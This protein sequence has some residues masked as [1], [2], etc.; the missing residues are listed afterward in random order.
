MT[1]GNTSGTPQ[2][3]TGKSTAATLWAVVVGWAL[4]R[5]VTAAYRPAEAERLPHPAGSDVGE[6]QHA[7][8]EA[9]HERGRGRR[10]ET[11]TEIPARGWKDIAWRVYEQFTQDRV[12]SEAAGVTYYALLALFPA[13]AALVSIYGLFA[14]PG[15]IESNLNALSGVLPG[16]ALEVVSDQVKRI[17]SKGGGTLGFGF[18]L[19]LVI[20]LWTA[21]AGMK[22]LFDAL[23]IVYD[24]RE[25]RS[26]VVLNAQ[27]IA[28][29][30][31][32]IAFILLALGGIVALPVV[33]DFV[34][35]SSGTEWLLALGRW[36]VLLAAVVLGLALIYR[37]GPSR[38][39]AQWKWITPGSLVAAVLWLVVS[40]LFSW[41]VSSFGNYNETYGSLGAV[42]G[43]MTWIWLSSI[44]ILMGAEINAEIEHQTATDTTEGAPKP[45]GARGATMADTLG[46]AKA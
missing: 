36:P 42:I 8:T 34:G 4:V 44:V 39:R 30:L 12:M 33:L 19:G 37:Y 45:L 29:T 16:G 35:L 17:A 6:K 3:L 40:M 5:I 2:S 46:A 27:S 38:E 13:I 41:Y 25:K 15:T 10:A 24:E 43:F 22:A 11:P 32:G 28:F 14:D 21:N 31:G 23:N 26:F 9:A 7:P 18:I 20:S 1:D